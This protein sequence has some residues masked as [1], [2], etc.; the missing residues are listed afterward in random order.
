MKILKRIVIFLTVLAVGLAVVGFLLPAQYHVERSLTV[1]APP[2]KV[3]AL[4]ASFKTWEDWTAWNLQLDPTLKR[5]IT[6]PDA[7]VGSTMSWDGKKTGDGVMT[8]TKVTAPKEFAYDLA[9]QNGSFKSVG[10]MTF[11]SSGDG[12]LV[13]WTDAGD[14]GGNPF[15]RW[16]GLAIDKMIGPDFEKGLAGL[17]ALAEKK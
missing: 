2:E 13:T 5:S 14:M 12:T 16:V 1:N 17:K 6:G 3:F 11:Q 9:F 7:A 10:T 4:A 15:L 8:L